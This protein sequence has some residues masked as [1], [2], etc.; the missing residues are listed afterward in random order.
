MQFTLASAVQRWSWCLPFLVVRVL[1]DLRLSQFS[2]ILWNE[3]VCVC[4]QLCLTCNSMD[5]SPTGSSV[6][7]IF[8]AG[9]LEI[10][11]SRGL[12]QSGIELC[13]WHLLHWQVDSLP[14]AIWEGPCGMKT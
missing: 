9:I 4:A 3:Y 8:Q 7:G 13:L 10:S 2:V 5:C 1:P 14:R 6:H 11:F 12:P